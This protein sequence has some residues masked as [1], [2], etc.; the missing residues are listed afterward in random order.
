MK[1][2]EKKVLFI[3]DEEMRLEVEK[4]ANI[5]IPYFVIDNKSN[6][7]N[8]L[9]WAGNDFGFVALD[10]KQDYDYEEIT[11]EQFKEVLKQK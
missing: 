11:L 7:Y 3:K 5:S 6:R 9:T 1:Q 8:W 2:F 10:L 4:L